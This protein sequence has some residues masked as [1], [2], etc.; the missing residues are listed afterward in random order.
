MGSRSLNIMCY[1]DYAFLTAESEDDLQRLV[2]EFKK[3]AEELNMIV[4]CEK[5]MTMVVAKELIRCKIVIN[6]KI[7]EQVSR[8]NYLGVTVSSE[9][10]VV[11]EV[12]TQAHKAAKI[13]GCLGDIVWTMSHKAKTRIYKACVRPLLTYTA[14]TRAETSTIKRIARTTEM[15][16]LR[17]I[18]GE[19]LRD[20]VRSSDI[21]EELEVQD[22]VRSVR[23]RRR[24]W[25][26][27]VASMQ[28]ERLAK[29]AESQ[30]PSTHRPLG[31]PP[32]RWKESWNSM[33]QEFC[34]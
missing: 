31:R 13:G 21:R 24:F 33:S 15:R 5:S 9:R 19:T 4:S 27:H 18:K 26:D 16:I 20:H 22:V 25:G 7:L 14:E 17:S 12:R 28:D 10:C 2:Y 30:K 32:K 1:A 6:G 3:A 11:E 34:Q 8:F 29:W 23:A